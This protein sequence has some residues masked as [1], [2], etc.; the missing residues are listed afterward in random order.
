MSKTSNDKKPASRIQNPVTRCSWCGTDPIYVKYHDEAWGVPE[1]NDR[2]L[3]AKLCLDGAQAGLSWIT[4]LKKEKNYYRAF[5]NFDPKKIAKYDQKKID[6]LL[7]NPGIVRN[8]LKVNAF[9]SNAQA[10]I[11]IKKEFG[12]FDKYIWSFTNYKTIH[13]KFSSLNEVPAKTEIAEQMSKDLKNRGFKFVGPT[14]V[15]AFMQAVGIVN[16]HVVDCFRYKEV[17]K[18]K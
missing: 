15:Y 11:E 18:I 2:K 9:I 7:N 16:D 3:F 8:K 10:Y 4:I 17:K 6:E 5:D 14:I 12:T 13:N 1:H